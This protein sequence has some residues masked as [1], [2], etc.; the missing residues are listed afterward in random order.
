MHYL[1]IPQTDARTGRALGW[2]QAILDAGAP[3][4]EPVAAAYDPASGYEVGS[5]LAQDE[6]VTAVLCGN[7]ELAIGLMRALGEAGRRVPDDVSVVGFDDQPL[8]AMWMPALTTVHQDFVDLGRRVFGLLDTL[9]ST[10][11]SRHTSS[12][13]T[14][15]GRPRE[16]RP[17]GAST[18]T[19]ARPAHGS[20]ARPRR[21][22][23]TR[24]GPAVAIRSNPS[25]ALPTR[26]AN[27]DQNACISL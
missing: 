21:T 20:R 1:A 16:R 13:K 14:T 10:G 27:D 2:R 22:G 19:T 25:P 4:H 17:S 26:Y 18:L 15:A 24:Q 9:L 12:A 5:L 11:E 6:T 3:L 23:S 8:A 7:D